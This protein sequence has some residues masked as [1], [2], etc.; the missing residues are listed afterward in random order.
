MELISIYFKRIY[1]EDG[2]S[3][4]ITNVPGKHGNCFILE[5]IASIVGIDINYSMN[6]ITDKNQY[7]AINIMGTEDGG[8]CHCIDIAEIANLFSNLP[9]ENPYR[10]QYLFLLLRTIVDSSAFTVGTTCTARKLAKYYVDIIA[11]AK[12]IA[13]SSI[14]TMINE[15]VK[16]RYNINI[17]ALKEDGTVD[18]IPDYID[19]VPSMAYNILYII[20]ELMKEVLYMNL[21]SEYRG[22]MDNGMF[23][24]GISTTEDVVNQVEY[25]V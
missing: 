2:H 22:S 11:N 7:F 3:F 9:Q 17:F 8:L 16:Y 23:E 5:D 4:A 1:F 10:L 21:I 6:F 13:P 20:I 24:H 19:K 25:K 15:R 14:Y 18:S 12:D